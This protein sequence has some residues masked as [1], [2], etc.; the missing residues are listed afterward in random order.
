MKLE[1]GPVPGPRR[2][3]VG[4]G[5]N[6]PRVEWPKGAKLALNVVVNYEEGSE[7]T[8]PAG[9]GHNESLGEVPFGLP[10][11]YRDL[12][13]E[14]VYEY[15]SRAGIWRLGRLFEQYKIKAT[16]FACAVA[17]ER[18]PDVAAWIQES[19]HDVCSH[20]WRWEEVWRL[21]R[22][23]EREHI[24]WAVQSFQESCGQRPP[25][26][27]CRYGASVNTRELVVEEGGFVYDSDYYG[28]D[29][30]FFTDV[31]GKQHL[32]VPYSLTYNDLRYVISGYGSPG[33][34]FDNCRRAIDELRREGQEGHPKMLS[35]GLH[36]RWA[37]Q[38][39]RTSAL[40][41]V[42]EYALDKE[43]VWFARRIDIAQWWLDH[44][45]GFGRDTAGV[46]STGASADGR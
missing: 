38:P 8:L 28:D 12:C 9:D 26:W 27:Y 25:G 23:E 30:P 32:V 5:R 11:E 17:V 4:Y 35:I 34:F 16:I 33:D 46:S 10:P 39:S 6:L 20:G 44:H 37:G 42:I 36:P 41:E 7:Y 22:E 43:D 18:N 2:D 13:M 15:G 24:R 1:D 40:R 45:A 29:L 21:S 19:G 3:Y 31:G 14:S